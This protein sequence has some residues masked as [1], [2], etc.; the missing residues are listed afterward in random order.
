[1]NNTINLDLHDLVIYIDMSY[2]KSYHNANIFYH[3]NI[4]LQLAIV[5]Y[6][7]GWIFWIPFGRFKLHGEIWTYDKMHVGIMVQVQ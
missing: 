4:L 5:F 6:K 2:P 7:Q 1:M 3:Y